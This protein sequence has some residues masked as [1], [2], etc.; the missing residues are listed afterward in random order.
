MGGY[1]SSNKLFDS[2]VDPDHAVNPGFFKT[3]FLPL[4]DICK[5]C[6]VSAAL[7]EVCSLRMLIHRVSEKK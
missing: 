5:T 4:R 3:L 1:L 7:V 6:V 2:D